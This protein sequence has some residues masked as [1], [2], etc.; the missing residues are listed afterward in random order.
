METLQGSEEDLFTVVG[1]LSSTP[2]PTQSDAQCSRSVNTN[3]N[4]ISSMKSCTD[5]D[6]KGREQCIPRLRI[7]QESHSDIYVSDTMDQP[8][9]E[10]NSTERTN[11]HA[12]SVTGHID[13]T[14]SHFPGQHFRLPSVSTVMERLAISYRREKVA[15]TDGSIPNT[16]TLLDPSGATVESVADGSSTIPAVSDNDDLPTYFAIEFLAQK[17]AQQAVLSKTVLPSTCFPVLA[18]H[19]ESEASV[20]ESET[21][22]GPH[23]TVNRKRPRLAASLDEGSPS[24]QRSAKRKQRSN[25]HTGVRTCVCEICNAVLSAPASLKTHMLIHSGDKP[26]PCGMCKAAFRHQSTLKR[27]MCIHTGEKKFTCE[28]CQSPFAR[29]TELKQHQRS[30]STDRP[31]TCKL[32]GSSYKHPKDLSQHLRAHSRSGSHTCN[33]CGSLFSDPKALAQHMQTHEDRT[34]KDPKALDHHMQTHEDPKALNQLMQTHEDQ[35]HEDPKARDQHMQ[36]HEDQTHEDPKAGDHHMQTHEDPKAGDQHMQ[37]HEDPKAGDQD[38]QIHEDRTHE[39]PTALDQHMQTHEGSMQTHG[40]TESKAVVCEVCD[41]L[42]SSLVELTRHVMKKHLSNVRTNTRSQDT[43]A[44]DI[45]HQ[46]SMCVMKFEEADQLNSHLKQNHWAEYMKVLAKARKVQNSREYPCK[47][48]G[49][50]LR[51][52][53]ALAQHI[54]KKHWVSTQDTKNAEDSERSHACG[55]CGMEYPRSASLA[56]HMKKSHSINLLPCVKCGHTFLEIQDWIKHT[57]VCS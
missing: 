47:I 7:K 39:D 15:G 34:H 31:F 44:G 11:L 29:K 10:H 12:V 50:G 49:V 28:I 55:V 46:C 57:D 35:T 5:E 54:K 14:A 17:S 56:Q 27:H 8:C 42:F 25:T 22:S 53:S 41:T 9:Y 3:N 16:P 19:L 2:H 13:A 48:C 26:Y 23:A 52:S 18:K 6:D 37:T 38:M 33:T 30:H 51:S 45:A 4:V 32:C 20:E 36:T 21:H 43:E 40:H 24:S 1:T